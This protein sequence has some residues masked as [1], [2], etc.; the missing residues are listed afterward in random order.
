MIGSPDD[1]E[2]LAMVIPLFTTRRHAR[3]TR[4]RTA[5]ETGDDDRERIER[6]KRHHPSSWQGD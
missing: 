3:P 6:A 5:L 2:R 4:D 1:S